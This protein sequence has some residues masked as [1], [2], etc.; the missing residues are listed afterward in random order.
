VLDR[1]TISNRALSA[2][3]ATAKI[4]TADDD[5]HVASVIHSHWDAVRLIS[6]RGG[7]KHQPRWNF[8]ERYIE[9]P[10]RDVTDITPLPY[11]WSAA[12]P[13]PD[14]ALRLC[15]IVTPDCSATGS[16]K[17]ANGEVLIKS[18]PPLGAWWLFDVPET[19]RWDAL[20]E[21]AFTAH[22]AFAICDEVNGDLGRKQSCWTEYLAHQSAAARVDAGEN[23][24]VVPQESDWVL[25]RGGHLYPGAYG[26]II[27]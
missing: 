10:A 3:G 5:S 1:V 6:L 19:V 9:I 20:F 18:T 15:E 2:T 21:A 16:W 27:V 24:P 8:A 13:M 4:V 25:A 17:F 23:P 14:G 26:R 11:G 7:P 22:L 12:C